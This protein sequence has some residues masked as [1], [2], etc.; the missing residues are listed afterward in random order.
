M[1]KIKVISIIDYFDVWGNPQDGWEVN[2]SRHTDINEII[3]DSNEAILQL[4]IKH[5]KLAE[6]CTLKDI[7]IEDNAD[8]IYINDI[9][10]SQPLYALWIK[11]I[12][13]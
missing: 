4:L 2:N 9:T 5:N 1:N 3:K 11:S 8:C 12:Q 10:N 6:F 13:E 7:E